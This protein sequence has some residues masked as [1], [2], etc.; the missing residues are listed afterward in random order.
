M[1]LVGR[2][3]EFQILK[4]C[5]S[6]GKPKFIAIYGRRRVGKP[7]FHKK[8]GIYYKVIDE[9]TLFYLSWIQP[10]RETLM[11]SG[12]KKGYWDK[13]QSLL[14]WKVWAGYAF[15]AIC[16]KHLFQ[17]S[18]ALGLSSTAIPSPWRYVP[19]KGENKTGTQIDL[20]FDRD[21]DAI[22]ICEIKYTDQPFKID[23][24]YAHN[25]L[26]KAKVF[27]A[28]TKTTK[29]IFISII[30]AGGLQPSMYSEEIITN[31]VT[32]DDLFKPES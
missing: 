21:D 25:L 17:I 11:K 3:K 8:K 26:N 9:F 22:S 10:I 6:S 13:Q 15:E 14:S 29:Q 12:M 4:R 19:S 24:Q 7:Y 20:L 5:F 23:K 31:V 28:K 27:Q 30:L 2:E 32:L 18:D 16:Y 1:N